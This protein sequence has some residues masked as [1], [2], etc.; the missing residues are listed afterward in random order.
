MDLTIQQRWPPRKRCYRLSRF[1]MLLKRKE[2]CLALKR[3][4]RARFQTEMVEF[5]ALPIRSPPQV[6]LKSGHFTSLQRS[7]SEVSVECR[8]PIDRHVGLQSDKPLSADISIETRPPHR[9]TCRPS[10]GRCIDR[11]VD[12]STKGWTNYA[13]SHFVTSRDHYKWVF[14][15]NRK[16]LIQF[17]HLGEQIACFI[18]PF[19]GAN[20]ASIVILFVR[21]V[22]LF[23]SLGKVVN[24]NRKVLSAKRIRWVDCLGRFETN[25]LLVTRFRRL[26]SWSTMIHSL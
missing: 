8:S 16:T 9:S 2:F 10:V 11:H 21:L 24:Y 7:I 18:R 15:M 1:A 22:A 12:L 13:R 4:D 5:I 19:A 25:C 3:G 23:T 20:Y 17:A 26:C 6:N 14:S